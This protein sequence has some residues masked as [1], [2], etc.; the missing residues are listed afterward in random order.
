MKTQFLGGK[1]GE[2]TAV[3]MY[4]Q[5]AQ[6][7][8]KEPGKM[9]TAPGFTEW[10][11]IGVTGQVRGAIAASDG[12]SYVIIA[13]KVYKI[14][15]TKTATLLGSIGTSTGQIRPADN[16]YQ[17][18][19]ADGVAG[20]CY[21]YATGVFE[22]ISDADF[23]NG[24]A[25]IV[26]T[27]NYGMA[28]M[29]DTEQ[30]YISGITALHG[31]FL[32][33]DALDFTSAS[34]SPDRALALIIDYYAIV[35]GSDSVEQFYYSGN[36]D[37]P[38]D[39]VRGAPVKEGTI[40]AHCVAKLDNS[41]VWLGTC[42]VVWRLEGGVAIRISNH[43]VESTISGWGTNELCELMAWKECGRAMV[44]I[45]HPTQGIAQVFDAS[46]RLWH[47]RASFS[48]G[49][50]GKWQ[51]SCIW[52]FAGKVLVGHHTDGKI[53]SLDGSSYSYGDGVK[54]FL[55]RWRFENTERKPF[56][57]PRITFD[58][59]QGVGL[60]TGQGS[61]PQLMFR[62]SADQGRT[63]SD[64]QTVSMGKIGNTNQDIFIT[65]LGT[66]RDWTFE[67]SGTDPVEVEIY[68]VYF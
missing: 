23:P 49:S 30:L 57:I 44:A 67:L 27:N 52:N 21:T 61:D 48:G 54:K 2:N 18:A 38:F 43:A 29:P 26:Y 51:A 42:G 19:F 12:N 45:T 59:K 5:T 22:Q 47:E 65:R 11:D 7:G 63:W 25:D 60:V 20:W 4:L 34:V 31:D 13:E 33:W 35:L 36:A 46:T 66:K 58:I 50:F 17:M 53:Y 64:I 3:N 16:G 10:L 37:F 68:G 14:T 28:I 56:T 6:E 32:I 41:I 55:R 62:T 39:I 9:R 40:G 15:P 24:C 1:D 8:E